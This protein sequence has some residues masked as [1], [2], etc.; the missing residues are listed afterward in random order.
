MAADRL[1]G[2]P[3]HRNWNR[4]EAVKGSLPVT[5]AEIVNYLH[6]RSRWLRAREW[7]RGRRYLPARFMDRARPLVVVAYPVRDARA[8]F[9]VALAVEQDWLTAPQPGREAYDEILFK[10]PGLIVLQL[11]RKNPCGCLGHRHPYVNEQPFAEPHEIFRG[12]G[13]GELDI[14]YTRVASWQPLPLSDIALDTKFLEGT[15]L[16]DFRAK[17]F[18]LKMLS[19]LLHETHHMVEAEAPETAVRERSIAFYHDALAAYVENAVDTM[20]LTIDRSFSRME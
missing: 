10:A 14:A 2:L 11:R 17:Q 12:A 16:E 1:N 20:S 18:R 19:I 8:A 7:L 13:V 6:G 9:Q 3:M 5:G 4:M 15:R